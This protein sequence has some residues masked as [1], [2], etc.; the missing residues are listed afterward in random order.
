MSDKN[1]PSTPMLIWNVISIRYRI[2]PDR[3]GSPDP[4]LH[5]ADT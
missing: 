1:N 3:S 5:R 4:G 2:R